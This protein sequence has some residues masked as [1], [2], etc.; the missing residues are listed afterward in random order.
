[1]ETTSIGSVDLSETRQPSLYSSIIICFSF[2]LACVMLRFWCRW[3][4]ASGLWLDDWLIL[5]ALGCGFGLM[6]DQLWW[7][8]RGL[9][10]HVWS[11][12]PNVVEYFY[13]G[14][15]TAELT[16]TGTIVFVKFS[17]LA[18]YWRVFNSSSSIKVPIS[19][20]ASA[21]LMW[22]IAVF[23]LT[24]LQCIPTRGIW[25]KSIQASCNVDSEKFLF[26]ISIPNILIDITL[27]L[28]PIPYVIKLNLSKNQKRIIISLFL[29][30]GFVCIASIMRLVSVLTQPTNEDITWNIINQS[31]WASVEAYFAIMS[32][33]RQ[34]RFTG[35]STEPS[36]DQAPF[37]SRPQ[38]RVR[39]LWGTSILK[40]GA[41]EDTRPF[42]TLDSAIED[43]SRQGSTPDFQLAGQPVGIPLSNLEA[44]HQQ[45]TGTIKVENVW[46]VEYS[47]RQA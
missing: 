35:I 7:L 19:I 21:V 47:L 16:Y 11:F 10:R 46:G 30:G 40:S 17:I 38:K 36:S 6:V 3:I 26:A 8:P 33:I 18:L 45:N 1:M 42:S 22:G 2:A 4:K 9:G 13:I 12:G 14:L 27:L 15:F 20:I 43:H 24:L 23:F 29:L 5:I 37:K 31:I 44:S 32:A 25:D 41:D 34:R 39:H 28:L